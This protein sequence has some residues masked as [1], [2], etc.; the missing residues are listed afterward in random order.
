MATTL[1]LETGSKRI[2]P[3]YRWVVVASTTKI[4]MMVEFINN[5]V[6]DLYRNII[7]FNTCSQEQLMLD[8]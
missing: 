6:V 3:S 7:I 5:V 4:E 2:N 8:L 1:V